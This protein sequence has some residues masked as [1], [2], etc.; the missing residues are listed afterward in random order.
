[1]L[2]K[3]L[4]PLFERELQKLKNEISSFSTADNIWKPLPNTINSAGNLALHICGNLQHYIGAVLGK[5]GYQRERD[6]EFTKRNVSL[7]LIIN[8]ID[9]TI[10]IVSAVLEKLDASRL[11]EIFPEEVGGKEWITGAFLIHLLSHLSYHLGQINYSRRYFS[12]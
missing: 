8:E 9:K 11:N 1:M 10:S 3:S 4:S 2:T 6:L 12:G 7:S 5:T